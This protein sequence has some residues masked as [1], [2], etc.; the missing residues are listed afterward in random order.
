V[1]LQTVLLLVPIPCEPGSERGRVVCVAGELLVT[2]EVLGQGSGGEGGLAGA[3]TGLGHYREYEDRG[4]LGDLRE[5]A[6]ERFLTF[7][8]ALTRPKQLAHYPIPHSLY[9]F[10]PNNPTMYSSAPSK[11][12]PPSLLSTPLLPSVTSF[13]SQLPSQPYPTL[14]NQIGEVLSRQNR[15][16][17]ELTTQQEDL[18]TELETMERQMS[19]IKKT[20]RGD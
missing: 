6:A 11:S 16:L 1:Q 14:A 19:E 7:R 20:T 3:G 18:W 8:Q 4:A 15:L 2:E 5:H 9:P 17:A 12:Q 13:L 10:S